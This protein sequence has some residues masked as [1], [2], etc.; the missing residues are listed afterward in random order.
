MLR[1][2]TIAKCYVYLFFYRHLPACI[3]LGRDEYLHRSCSATQYNSCTSLQCQYGL[4]N[5]SL[6][7]TQVDTAPALCVMSRAFKP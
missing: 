2:L 7:R 6:P 4:L 1:T 5:L 3:T